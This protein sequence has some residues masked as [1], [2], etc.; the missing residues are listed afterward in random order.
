MSWVGIWEG[1]QQ[2]RVGTGE[3][4]VGKYMGAGLAEKGKRR[5]VW[6]LEGVP[7]TLWRW[8]S[9]PRLPIA[10]A[11]FRFASRLRQSRNVIFRKLLNSLRLFTLF[12]YL[13]IV[14]LSHMT[15]SPRRGD[16]VFI[17]VVPGRP[18]WA[19]KAPNSCEWS[20]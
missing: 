3:P 18:C 11:A 4:G 20:E 5:R 9:C 14:A 13:M 16:P 19:W 17:T 7:V 12:L 6:G 15:I 2:P 10:A 8:E 1:L